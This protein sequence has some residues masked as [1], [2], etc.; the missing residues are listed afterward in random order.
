[1]YMDNVLSGVSDD[2]DAEHYY[3]H[4]RQL[5]AS[6]EMNLRQRTANSSKLTDK[7]VA[8]N[9]IAT[10]KPKVLGLEWDSNADTMSFPFNDSRIRD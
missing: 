5:L 9:T 2:E 1:M 8:E 4:L 3:S 7:L 6:G 10:D